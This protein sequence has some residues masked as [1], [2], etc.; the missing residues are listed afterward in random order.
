MED[1]QVQSEEARRRFRA[2]LDSVEHKDEHVTISRYNT[3][4][5][6][7]VPW[8]WYRQARQALREGKRP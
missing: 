2:L 8:Q 3:P 7:L 1:K 6:V 5:A 4:A